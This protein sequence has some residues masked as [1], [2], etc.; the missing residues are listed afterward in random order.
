MSKLVV[1]SLGQ[2]D[3][4]TGFPYVTAQVWSNSGLP[5]VKFTGKLPIDQ[6]IFHLYRRWQG[7]YTA[8][9]QRL[10]LRRAAIRIEENDLTNFSE[11]EFNQICQELQQRINVWLN[12][13][14]FR[15]IERHL[16]SQLNV[17]DEVQVVIEVDD[18][19]GQ[20]IPWQ[21]W[22][23]FRDYRNA[24]IALSPS[25]YQYVESSK[26][27]RKKIRILAILG[28][29]AGIDI[30]TDREILEALPKAETVFLVKPQRRELDRWL[31]DE[32]GWDILFFAGHSQTEAE[33]GRMYI[34]STESLTIPQLSYALTK[35]IERGLQLAI[36]NS[37]DGLGLARQLAHLHIPQMIVMRE[38]V[39]DRIAQEFLKNFLTIF[40]R[41]KSLYASVREAR[42]QLQGLESEY[43]CASWLPIIFQNPATEPMTWI[44]KKST[45]RRIGVLA[46]AVMTIAALLATPAII[47]KVREFN[48][49]SL[50]KDAE[51]AM[52]YPK[53]WQLSRGGM[54]RERARF[55]SPEEYESDFLEQV[56]LTIELLELPNMSLQAY[57]DQT[58]AQIS[59]GLADS[60]GVSI[61][62]TTL[63]NH[64]ASRIV[65]T[66]RG[67][68][69]IEVSQIWTLKDNQAY[70]ITYTAKK[71]KL[72]E[73]EQV[74]QEMI[75]SFRIE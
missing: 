20:R 60:N 72:A 58:V 28:D 8:A 64:E 61:Y 23:F 50:Y 35:A 16:R 70:I 17:A 65:Y 5:S 56:S 62:K 48:T 26:P 57:T 44:K 53:E 34:N 18:D 38:P 24:E 71:E 10:G 75:R 40:S 42:E 73:L 46:A 22:D 66:R 37:C 13:E 52:K 9:Y 45:N 29:A 69:D 19:L 51:I 74:I 68:P 14:N 7:L 47:N 63:A 30:Q 59:K 1:I 41:G 36:F 32:R 67:Q 33:T 27:R 21:L 6:E 39:P 25:D 31:W 11:V 15:S 55:I 4:K 2:R 54:G 12:S 43:P 49:F 3:I